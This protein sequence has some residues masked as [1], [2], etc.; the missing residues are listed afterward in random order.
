MRYVGVWARLV[1]TVIDTVVLGAMGWLLAA[2][3]GGT[4]ASGFELSGGPFFLYVLVSFA[5]FIVL[6]ATVGATFGKLALGQ[7]VVMEDGS[8][9]DWRASTIRNVLRVVD[10]LPLFY[11]V[12]AILVWNSDRR[13][14][15][16]DRVAGTVVVRRASV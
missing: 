3:T 7:R 8:P 4:T 13:Q 12:G 10:V 5:Y 9:V 14:R 15:L 1:A 6:E 2:F 16:G 11:L